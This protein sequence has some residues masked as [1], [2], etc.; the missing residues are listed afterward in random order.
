MKNDDVCWVEL[1]TDLSAMR[2]IRTDREASKTLAAGK[3]VKM[4]RR[5]RAVA[6]IRYKVF[7]RSRGSCE[8]CGSPVIENSGHMHEVLHRGK[9]GEISVENSVFICPPCHI[10]AHKDRNQKWKN[11]V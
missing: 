1:D 7:L 3:L 2:I 8:I 6:I 9:G 5:S 11:H 4:A 10:R